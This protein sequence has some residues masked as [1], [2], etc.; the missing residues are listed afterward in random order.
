MLEAVAIGNTKTSP[1]LH[2]TLSLPRALKI[3][4]ERRY[5]YTNWLVRWPLSE[6]D[7][8]I[9]LSNRDA[10]HAWL[11]EEDGDTDLLLEWVR[12]CRKFCTKDQEV[13]QT[14]RPAWQ[15]VQ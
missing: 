7:A 4:E 15:Q 3:M 9:N 13:V 11:S 1:F 12:F 10:Q 14:K 8:I 5:L 2:G 6:Q